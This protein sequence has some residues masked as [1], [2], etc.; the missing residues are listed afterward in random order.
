MD[1]VRFIRIYPE[2]GDAFLVG[3]PGNVFN[4]EDF[5]DDY[6]KYVQTWEWV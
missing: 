5:I 1:E 3:I 4:V 6:L 2:F